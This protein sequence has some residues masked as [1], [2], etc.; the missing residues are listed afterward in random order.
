MN[1]ELSS[2]LTRYRHDEGVKAALLVSADGFL[3]A[4]SAAHGLNPEAIAAQVA[5]VLAVG[6]RLAIELGR[7]ATR[8]V[9]F[10]L[11]G[12]NVIVAP[13]DD[14]LLLVLV[15]DPA[16]LKLSYSLREMPES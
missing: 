12:L 10:E 11:T 9:T 13:F 2:L 16:A 14:T 1:D 6:E 5:D 3:V 15:G 4:A 8:F 7:Q